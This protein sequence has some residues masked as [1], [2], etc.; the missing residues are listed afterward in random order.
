M[1]TATI[2]LDIPDEVMAKLA[3]GEYKRVGGV[4]QD[5][6]G[7]IVMWLKEG[8]LSPSSPE[9]LSLGLPSNMGNMLKLTG[10]AASILNLGATIVFGIETLSRLK[11]ID[12]KLDIIV[13]KLDEL[14]RK[15]NKI[16][17]SV[18]IGFA[19]TFQSLEYLKKYQE[20]ELAGEL[21]SAVNSAWSCQFLEPESNQRI[22]RIEQALSKSSGVVEKLLLHTEIEMN[23]AIEW[24]EKKRRDS[25]DFAIDDSVIQALF[26]FRQ[27][28]LACSVNASINAEAGDTYTA[29]KKL[30][31]D[32][33]KLFNLLYQLVN[34]CIGSSNN[35]AYKTLLDKSM[36]ELMPIER[37]GLWVERFDSGKTLNNVIEL[38]RKDGFASDSRFSSDTGDLRPTYFH[39]VN[40][41]CGMDELLG[42]E[43][44]MLKN[45]KS[46]F[47]LVD[48]VYEDLERLKGYSLEYEAMHSMNFSIHEY[49]KMLQI[50]ELQEGRQ[51]I[52]FLAG[53]VAHIFK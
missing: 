9:D 8:C 2:V 27:T 14:G 4:I 45:T 24:M 33:Q 19:N 22:I 13:E 51:L 35:K 50:D 36:L 6:D 26:R 32:Q 12:G 20:I 7:K 3:T 15:I 18:D 31:K 30:Q 38:L 21:N 47:D 40:R 16:Q 29:S 17:W 49:R 46:F 39:A 52:F 53:G 34:L 23:D 44:S 11:K 42:T 25:S 37:I 43:D 5:R 28:C 10:A 48:G 41:E 1:Q